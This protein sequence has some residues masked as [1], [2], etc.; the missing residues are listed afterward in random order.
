MW[1]SYYAEQM[2][3][4]DDHFMEAWITMMKKRKNRRTKDGHILPLSYY[5]IECDC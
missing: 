1:P 4:Q 3:A 5:G 2:N